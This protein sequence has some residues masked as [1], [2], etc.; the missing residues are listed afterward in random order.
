[1]TLN[2]CH[3]AVVR[4]VVPHQRQS[5][6]LPG[7]EIVLLRHGIGLKVA[8]GATPTPEEHAGR[9]TKL[10]ILGRLDIEHN[11]LGS[12]NICL[13]WC[14]IGS[15]GVPFNG[16]PSYYSLRRTQNALNLRLLPGI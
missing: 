9:P 6:T 3:V 14:W 12:E 10:G 15:E 4:A 8:F 2:C 5:A 7:L 16:S 11:N 13:E 1:M